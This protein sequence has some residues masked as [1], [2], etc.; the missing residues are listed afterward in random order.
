MLPSSFIVSEKSSGSVIG[1]LCLLYTMFA[2]CQVLENTY[3]SGILKFEMPVYIDNNKDCHR[4]KYKVYDLKHNQ[5]H[6]HVRLSAM[7]RRF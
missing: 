4:N 2:Q 3:V 6:R 7:L 1:D 5:K